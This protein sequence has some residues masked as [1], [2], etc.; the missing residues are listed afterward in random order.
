MEMNKISWKEL[1]SLFSIWLPNY[2]NIVLNIWIRNASK[3]FVNC[4]LASKQNVSDKLK[5]DLNIFSIIN[6]TVWMDVQCSAWWQMPNDIYIL[7][8]FHISYT[9]KMIKHFFG[10]KWE[11]E[12]DKRNKNDIKGQRKP[13]DFWAIFV[14]FGKRQFFI[15]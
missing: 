8:S 11:R 13:T 7:S 1:Q 3:S 2:W 12:P 14:R 6:E 15:I 4:K 10:W 5:W 9:Y